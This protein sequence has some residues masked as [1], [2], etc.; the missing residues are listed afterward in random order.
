MGKSLVSCFLT[1]GVEADYRCH[2]CV[3]VSLLTTAL[4]PAKTDEPIE[5]PFGRH[6]RVGTKNNFLERD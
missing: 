6:T 5:T 4:S 2:T 1:H 3:C